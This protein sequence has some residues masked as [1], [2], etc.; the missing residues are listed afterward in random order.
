MSQ[1]TR[2]LKAMRLAALMAAAVCLPASSYAQCVMNDRPEVRLAQS[3]V[4]F[5]G[6]VVAT[7]AT[8]A[9]GEHVI[10]DIA[11]FRVDDIWKGDF[12]REIRVGAD[13]PFERNTQYLVF[14]GG[15]PLGTS[16]LCEWAEPIDRAKAKLDWLITNRDRQIVQAVLTHTVLPEARRLGRTPS[17]LPVLSRTVSVC[18]AR[19]D[20]TCIT[21]SQLAPFL[22]DQIGAWV[23]GPE[24]GAAVP[25]PNE[26]AALVDALV[27]RNTIRQPLSITVTTELTM[28]PVENE[29]DMMVRDRDTSRYSGFTLPGYLRDNRA[30][31]YAF[32]ACGARCGSGWLF[33]LQKTNG[34]WQV[35]SRYMLWIR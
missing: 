14:A 33:L 4:V 25:D 6:T 8:G 12:V 5:L 21:K 9:R 15:T 2:E 17:A 18:E 23:L 32:Y 29:P 26:R 28:V 20:Q 10:V 30:L 24:P 34:D 1:M 11:T 22:K 27:S 35:Q 13:R 31:V 19:H 16:I 3:T 7:E